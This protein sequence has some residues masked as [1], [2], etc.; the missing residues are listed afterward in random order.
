LWNRN[1]YG[2]HAVEMIAD[3]PLFGVGVGSFHLLV[4][5]YARLYGHRIA[6]DNAQTGTG[7]SWIPSSS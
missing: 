5:D 2:R 4:T 6:S 1:E 3:Y 7:T